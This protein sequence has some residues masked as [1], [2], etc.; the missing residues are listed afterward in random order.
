MTIDTF[1]NEKNEEIGHGDSI[2][3][4]HVWNE[5]WLQRPDLPDGYDGW[6]AID[7]TPQETSEDR[8]QC[9]PAPVKAIKLGQTF[10]NYDAPFIFAEVNADS[11][12]WLVDDD[13]T[14]KGLTHRSR[15]HVGK[16][17]STT[18]PGQGIYDRL[19]LTDEYKQPEGSAEEEANFKRAFTYAAGRSEMK[20][21]LFGKCERPIDIQIFYAETP[22]FGEPIQLSIRLTN[23]SGF[24]INPDCFILTANSVFQVGQVHKYLLQIAID[25]GSIEA[26]EEKAVACEIPYEDYRDK[27]APD[28]QGFIRLQAL[29]RFNEQCASE[30]VHIVVEPPTDDLIELVLSYETCFIG[31]EGIT[32]KI[33]L[34]NKTDSLL[35]GG[36][37]TIDG[38][39]LFPTANYTVPSLE[40]KS[41]V[42]TEIQIKPTKPGTWTVVVNFD[43]DQII[44]M[45]VFKTIVVKE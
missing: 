22:K 30:R 15:A 38:L 5:V 24:N 29:M 25:S 17:I 9:G 41:K 26:N 27:L 43:T 18:A 40:V 6:Q 45:K 10:I 35:L 3:N 13:G 37:L 20:K 28:G 34:T 36:K 14:I 39:N 2:W 7:A 8:M 4:F 11:C 16:T 19:D 44:D 1:F 12:Y 32:A 33:R 42:E 31:D 21:Y 23:N